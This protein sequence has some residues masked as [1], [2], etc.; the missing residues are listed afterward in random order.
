MGKNKQRKIYRQVLLALL[1]VLLNFA[2]FCGNTKNISAEVKN[3]NSPKGEVTDISVQYQKLHLE[4]YAFDGDCIQNTTEIH[5]YIYRD[6]SNKI[7]IG[8][9]AADLYNSSANEK[10]NCDNYHGFEKDIIINNE[11]GTWNLEVYALDL[12]SDGSI[13]GVYNPIIYAGK[14]TFEEEPQPYLSIS[15]SEITASYDG[16]LSKNYIEVNTDNTGSYSVSSDSSWLK[17]GISD[18]KDFADTSFSFTESGYLYLFAEE[19]EGTSAR[20]AI[21][22]ISH[23][24]DAEKKQTVTIKQ[25]GKPKF[26][27]QLF[28]DQE[29]ITADS[30]GNLSPKFLS[31]STADTG[32]YNVKSS[33]NWLK[34]CT[35]DN[36]AD[37]VTELASIDSSKLYL[38]A[39]KN[40]S[41]KNRSCI[42]TIIHTEDKELNKSVIITQEA[43]D[44][45]DSFENFSISNDM[46][47]ASVN[48]ETDINCIEVETVNTDGFS[49]KTGSEWIHL[50][51][52]SSG[53]QTSSLSFDNSSQFYIFVDKSSNSVEREGTITVTENKGNR[54]R[55]ITVRQAE[56]IPVLKISSHTISVEQD[57]TFSG[58]NAILIDTEN[59]GGFIVVVKD[60]EWLRIVSGENAGFSDGFTTRVFDDSGNIY[61]VAKEN[62][63]GEIRTGQIFVEHESGGKSET[64]TVS[65]SG[66]GLEEDA[67]FLVDTQTHD[68][69]QPGK[70]ISSA[71]NIIADDTVNWTVTSSNSAWLKVSRDNSLSGDAYGS[72]SGSGNAAFYIVVNKNDAYGERGEWIVVSAPGHESYEIYVTQ[73]AKEVI[74][75]S[76]MV[77]NQ[78]K[79]DTTK[80]TFG[81]EKTSKVQI[82]YPDLPELNLEPID[83]KNC[84]EKI[85]YK[86]TKPKIVTVNKK[87]VIKG[88]KKGK[89]KIVVKLTL[90]DEEGNRIS[91]MVTVKVK[92]GRMKVNIKSFHDED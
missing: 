68:F 6:P 57:G 36:A 15:D 62:Q 45:S 53:N 85:K 20:T 63:T 14:I 38:F 78:I 54:S 25:E 9:F 41:G 91:R 10:Y 37:A 47:N 11:T 29:N 84:V 33:S 49:V 35:S 75:P 1:G 58:N 8:A 51:K 50:A 42:I 32:N 26:A 76:E 74:I 90:N 4:G 40:L 69:D 44:E 52:T 5:V 24:K 79:F 61:L 7:C 27:A 3:D 87:G 43:D 66:A 59:T 39:E 28:V 30:D 71:V 88:K 86:S 67:V 73:A 31:V 48:G 72:V 34:F 92:V 19:N 21:L 2:A 23:L 16:R 17:I 60:T 18:W 82:Y 56:L 81:R 13:A 64:I 70:A 65:Q 12:N 77:I 22:T 55:T 80:K 83:I 89:G 46:I